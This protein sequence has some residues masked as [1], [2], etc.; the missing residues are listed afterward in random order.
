MIARHSCSR[1]QQ[2]Q[3]SPPNESTEFAP[4]LGSDGAGTRRNVLA[5]GPDS[6]RGTNRRRAGATLRIGDSGAAQ[7]GL[8]AEAESEVDLQRGPFPRYDKI[9][10]HGPNSGS[11]VEPTQVDELPGRI[12]RG[13]LAK[14]SSESGVAKA[15]E[16][17]V[18]CCLEAPTDTEQLSDVFERPEVGPYTSSRS[19]S[20]SLWQ[21]ARAGRRRDERFR[22]ACC[23]TRT[24]G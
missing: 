1:V 21:P 10:R 15:E 24:S 7:D 18:L 19:I 4:G 8:L 2:F 13:P 3:Q 22:D 17:S 12:S 20:L 16:P 23:D 5:R 6:I 9:V 14:A 11:M